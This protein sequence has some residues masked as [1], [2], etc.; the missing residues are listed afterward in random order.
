MKSLAKIGFVLLVSCLLT[1]A[2]FAQSGD[3]YANLP[4]TQ[5]L[6]GFPEIGYPSALVDVKLYAAFDDP[7]SGQFWAQ[8]F[9]YAAASM[10][11]TAKSA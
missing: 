7:A 8:S 5:S 2:A 6:Q 10:C 3:R 1:V 9:R 4:Q 11:A